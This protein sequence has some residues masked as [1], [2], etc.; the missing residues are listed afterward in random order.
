VRSLDGNYSGIAIPGP[1]QTHV[2]LNKSERSTRRRYTLA[3]ELGHAL[4]AG[5]DRYRVPLDRT[6]EESLCQLF[7][8]EALMPSVELNRY[9]SSVGFPQ[10]RESLVE[11][12]R[13]FRV[14]I[15]AAVNALSS[16]HP[17]DERIALIAASRRPHTVRSSEVA[18]RV[19]AASAP[20][21]MF[22]PHGKRLRSIGLNRLLDWVKQMSEAGVEGCAEEPRVLLRSLR[23]GISGWTG[24]ARW[25]AWTVNGPGTNQPDALAVVVLLDTTQLRLLPPGGR[26]GPRRETRNVSHAG[27]ER[28]PV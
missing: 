5:L 18:L 24:P 20:Q 2:F 22:A 10:S 15:S 6:S 12:C 3:H 23:S 8:R 1:Q 11:F 28:L 9:F 17:A 4:L 26:G 14:S 16:H 21:P 27:E 19:D 13:Y 7:A 25:A